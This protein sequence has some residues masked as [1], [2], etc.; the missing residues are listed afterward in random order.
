MGSVTPFGLIN[1]RDKKV[2]FILDEDLINGGHE[3][4]YF[5]PMENTATTSI[6]PADLLKFLEAV[7]HPPTLMKFRMENDQ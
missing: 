5:H 3:K 1:D 7:N 2:T 4:L 6:A